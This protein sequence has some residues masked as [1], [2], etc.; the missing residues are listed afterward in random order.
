MPPPSRRKKQLEKAQQAKKESTQN[1]SSNLLR[2]KSFYTNKTL[3]SNDNNSSLKG[4]APWYFSGRAKSTYIVGVAGG[5]ASGK[6]SVCKEV[7]KR[8][9]IPS[10]Q[11]LSLDNFYKGLTPYQRK[12]VSEETMLIKFVHNI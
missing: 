9:G 4:R 1:T 7:I 3:E 6:T 12:N 11:I 5:T 2:M 10:V 8:L